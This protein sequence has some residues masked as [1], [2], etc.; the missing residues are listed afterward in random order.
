MLLWMSYVHNNYCH[1]DLRKRVERTRSWKETR[2]IST[3]TAAVSPR[4]LFFSEQRSVKQM[5]IQKQRVNVCI[6]QRDNDVSR[7]CCISYLKRKFRIDGRG[8][9]SLNSSKSPHLSGKFSRQRLLMSCGKPNHADVF[10]NPSS[11]VHWNSTV[12][13]YVFTQ[14]KSRWDY[15]YYFYFYAH[16]Y[17]WPLSNAQHFS[18]LVFI[19]NSAMRSHISVTAQQAPYLPTYGAKVTFALWSGERIMSERNRG[20]E[21]DKCLFA[22]TL[23]MKL[24][25]SSLKLS[26]SSLKSF[27]FFTEAY[28]QN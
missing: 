14:T 6:R 10:R 18:N 27:Q 1:N 25:V 26:V 5:M 24:R 23:V 13:P 28:T 17:K 4:G 22:V 7:E 3:W 11:F 12:I 2:D 19:H 8:G 9:I 20:R 16:H 21:Q 15:Y